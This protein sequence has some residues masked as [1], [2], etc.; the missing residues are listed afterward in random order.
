[1]GR[2]GRE[3]AVRQFGWAQIARRT[4]AIYERVLSEVRR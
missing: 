3:R 2:R 1:M 4:V